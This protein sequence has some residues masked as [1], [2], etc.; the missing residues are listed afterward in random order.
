M[1]KV[2]SGLALLA[3][4]LATAQTTQI[5]P[6]GA[7][8]VGIPVTAGD[9]QRATIILTT[10]SDATGVPLGTAAN[11]LNVTSASGGSSGNTV[12]VTGSGSLNTATANATYTINLSGGRSALGL[13]LSGLTASGATLTVERSNDGGTTWTNANTTESS[14]TASLSSTITAD[15][16]ARVGVAGATNIRL[17][18]STTGTGTVSIAYNATAASGPVFLVGNLP[19]YT[20]PDG[21]IIGGVDNR[22]V[23]GT[24]I[25]TNAGN[26]DAGTQRFVTAANSPEVINQTNNL[27]TTR[28]VTKFTT[29]TDGYTYNNYIAPPGLDPNANYAPLAVQGYVWNGSAALFQRGD[30]TGTFTVPQPVATASAGAAYTAVQGAASIVLKNSPGNLYAINLVNSTVAGFVVAYNGTAAPASGT[31]LSA[32]NAAYCY[33][34]AASST[35]D[36]VFAVPASFTTGITLLLST[37]C[38]TY[39]PVGTAPIL[40]GGQAK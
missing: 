3:P 8:T 20:T 21:R 23:A 26:A 30:A 19:S 2:L 12:D 9:G 15:G 32:A 14:A 25:S 38:T 29:A 17:R 16:Q 7:P 27:Q 33:Q 6:S 34:V 5:V 1:R 4:T 18:V 24:L 35:L 36:K 13:R 39:T 22:Y 31:A 10:P 40:F 37:S 11:P 28:I